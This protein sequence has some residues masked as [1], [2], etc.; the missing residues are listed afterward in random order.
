M[1]LVFGVKLGNLFSET[2]NCANISDD[3]VG[4]GKKENSKPRIP[5][6]TEE[7]ER[8]DA[9]IFQ[10]FFPFSS[11]FSSQC[12]DLFRPVQFLPQKQSNLLF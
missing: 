11:D 2:L 8:D 1:G 9:I 12:S 3:K 10:L 7:K 5:E 4:A 6:F